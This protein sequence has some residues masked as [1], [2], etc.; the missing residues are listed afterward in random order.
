[1][2]TI[3]AIRT[4]NQVV[5]SEK[6]FFELVQNARQLQPVEI[7]ETEVVESEEDFQAYVE[8][9]KELEQNETLDFDDLKS[10]WLNGKPANV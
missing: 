5:L 1:M 6:E 9:M 7:V 8:G 4:E 10:S 3:H 2:L